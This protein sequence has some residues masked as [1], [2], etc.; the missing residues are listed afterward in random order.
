M[1]LNN[2]CNAYNPLPSS[3]DLGSDREVMFRKVLIATWSDCVP[4][5]S[6][7][8]Q[9]G[10][11]LGGRLFGGRRHSPHVAKPTNPY[12]RTAP[13][14]RAIF[15]TAL[16]EA[17]RKTRAEAIHPGYGFLSENAEFA[18]ACLARGIVFIGRLR[19]RCATSV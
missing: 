1:Q 2:P 14:R 17:A 16:L 12:H 5:H 6:N 4:Y 19:S 7:A 18:E 15:P 9:D 3:A 10:R 11:C 13:P 8:A